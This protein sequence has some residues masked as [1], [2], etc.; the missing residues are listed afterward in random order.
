MALAGKHPCWI[1]T[2][3]QTSCLQPAS[4]KTWK[5]LDPRVAAD[6]TMVI[7]TGARSIDFA[8]QCCEELKIPF[9]DQVVIHV[10]GPHTWQDVL[11]TTFGFYV[12][13]VLHVLQGFL[14][15]HSKGCLVLLNVNA[16]A[17]RQHTSRATLSGFSG[18][19]L[20]PRDEKWPPTQILILAMQQ[21]PH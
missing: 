3:F 17:A 8:R 13:H 16:H 6:A 2:E 7:E 10:N 18:R 15:C 19:Q 9:P 20:R 14:M 21:R 12:P 1:H 11:G 5:V 4:C